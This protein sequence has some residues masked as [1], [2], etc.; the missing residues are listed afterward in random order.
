MVMRVRND[1]AVLDELTNIKHRADSEDEREDSPK[2]DSKNAPNLIIQS[3]VQNTPPA[4]SGAA[5]PPP[6]THTSVRTPV[7]TYAQPPPPVYYQHHPC[8]APPP[9]VVLSKHYM[10]QPVQYVE[11][12]VQ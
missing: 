12:Y 4:T 9:P 7:D 11:E 8:S 3:S 10:R 5:P 1:K 6:V 2:F